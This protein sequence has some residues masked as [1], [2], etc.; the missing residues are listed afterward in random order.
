MQRRRDH[1]SIDLMI[2]YEY[3][4]FAAHFVRHYY[5]NTGARPPLV[6]RS[7]HAT[8]RDHICHKESF[9]DR[10]EL[11]TRILYWPRIDCYISSKK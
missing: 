9:A 2:L 4:K 11:R 8:A 3:Q 7:R 1:T 10:F 6:I 5:S